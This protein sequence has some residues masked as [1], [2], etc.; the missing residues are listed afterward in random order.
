MHQ[1]RRRLDLQLEGLVM[2]GRDREVGVD[3]LDAPPIEEDGR[4][5][6]QCESDQLGAP[7][8]DGRPDDGLGNRHR[9]RL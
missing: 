9:H 8:A 7:V 5:V 4:S 6:L 2:V 1:V 3:Q